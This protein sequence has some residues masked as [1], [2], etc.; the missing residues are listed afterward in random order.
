MGLF[1][2]KNQIEALGG[3][4]NIYSEENNGTT[5]TVKFG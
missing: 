3:Q 1:M 4:I 2:V 5:F